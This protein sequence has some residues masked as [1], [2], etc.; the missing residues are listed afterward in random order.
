V[1]ARARVCVWGGGGGGGGGINAH[2]PFSQN[3]F[4]LV[5]SCDLICSSFMSVNKEILY[6]GGFIGVCHVAS[7]VYLKH[8]QQLNDKL[9]LA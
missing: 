8:S 6:Y 5:G 4:R 9:S 7:V 3:V 1:C 2:K